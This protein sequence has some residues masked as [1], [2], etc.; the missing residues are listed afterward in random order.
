MGEK[1]APKKEYLERIEELE[2][3]YKEK[4]S[5]LEDEKYLVEYT[6]DDIYEL[7]LFF[8]NKVKWTS[9]QALGVIE[10]LKVIDDAEKES[11]KGL[12][13]DNLFIEAI[14]YYLSQHQDVGSSYAEKF[15]RLYKPVFNIREKLIVIRKEIDEA[16]N[17]IDKLQ[18][19][20]DNGIDIEKE[21]E[22][23]EN[24]NKN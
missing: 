20:I 22:K 8:K 18:F 9:S 11:K 13:L 15:I 14:A 7:R 1:V 6:K 10:I 24:E 2:K 12:L 19:S 3:V 17:E 4:K 5:K 23:L 16:K 21:V